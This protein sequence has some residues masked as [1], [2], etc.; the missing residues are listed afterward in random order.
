MPGVMQHRKLGSSFLVP[1][2]RCGPG[3]NARQIIMYQIN[4]GMAETASRVTARSWREETR[5]DVLPTQRHAVRGS[6]PVISTPGVILSACG[7]S[8]V[9]CQT[10]EMFATKQKVV[11]WNCWHTS[12]HLLNVNSYHLQN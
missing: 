12:K 8:G 4:A 5:D 9:Q 6:S 10:L 1:D 11:N 7:I 3:A 2:S